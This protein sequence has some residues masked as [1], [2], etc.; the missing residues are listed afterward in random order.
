MQEVGGFSLRCISGTDIL[1]SFYQKWRGERIR[2]ERAMLGGQQVDVPIPVHLQKDL[3]FWDFMPSDPAVEKLVLIARAFGILRQET[4]QKIKKDVIRYRKNSELD[5]DIV[6]LAAN[7][8]EAVQILE[9]PDCRDDRREVQK[10]LD[11]LL[12]Q[13]ETDLQK[14]E[15]RGRLE[16]FLAERLR[17]EFR[18]IGQDTPQYLMEKSIIQEF[19]ADNKLGSKLNLDDSNLNVPPNSNFGFSV[20][21]EN[22]LSK[23][24]T[25][26][27]E[28]VNQLSS[29]RKF[30]SHCGNSL[31]EDDRFCSKCGTPVPK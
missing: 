29:Q 3:V 31:I 13:A 27:D 14:Q 23:P 9:L 17:N 10:Q 24:P 2:A 4:N 18:K 8:E 5:E 20:Q 7:W 25:N 15:L 11:Q 26:K 6:T 30:C 21:P 22:P 12:E 28:P 1:R 19:I 16:T